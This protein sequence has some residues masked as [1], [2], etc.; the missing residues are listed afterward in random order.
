MNYVKRKQMLEGIYLFLNQLSL[1]L[2]SMVVL[3]NV[4]ARGYFLFLNNAPELMHA[5]ALVQ[6]T[7]E[8]IT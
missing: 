3:N 2:L 8:I 4:S 5:C 6:H 7:H 1:I